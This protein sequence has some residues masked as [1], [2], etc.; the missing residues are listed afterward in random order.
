MFQSLTGAIQTPFSINWQTVEL[1]F[2][3]LTGAI[4]TKFD[5]CVF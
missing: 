3:S 5:T 1:K 4:Q 2:Q